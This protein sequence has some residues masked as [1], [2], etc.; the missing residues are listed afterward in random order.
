MKRLDGRIK[1]SCDSGAKIRQDFY[2]SLLAETSGYQVPEWR[3]LIRD[4]DGCTLYIRSLLALRL[5]G[6]RN[7]LPKFAKSSF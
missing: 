6:M 1:P 7:G 4:R 5:A 2:A 3:S